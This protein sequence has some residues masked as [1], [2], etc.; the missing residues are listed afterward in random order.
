MKASRSPLIGRVIR[1]DAHCASFGFASE[2]I[3]GA[4]LQAFEFRQ[5]VDSN[6]EKR[7]V[8]EVGRSTNGR[9]CFRPNFAITTTVRN[10]SVPAPEYK[11]C[12]GAGNSNRPIAV[13]RIYPHFRAGFTN[14]GTNA[15]VRALLRIAI[16]VFATIG[17]LFVGLNILGP[18]IVLDQL[19]D[20]SSRVLRESQ[21]PSGEFVASIESSVCKD[22]ARSG[23]TVY[24]R[25]SGE[26]D[27]RGIPFADNSSTDFEL[28]W[29][30]DS[31]LE[32]IGPSQLVTD[33]ETIGS[34]EDVWILTGEF[35]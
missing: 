34:I 10:G 28:T 4:R 15:F 2:Y 5:G 13:I 31:K 25:R 8:G 3:K 35:R 29:V 21:S 14:S 20:C 12:R 7:Q 22:S 6:R 27:R 11:A 32:V 23:T 18:E 19:T 24:L 26:M 33:G 1:S 16:G 30:S 9:V 17:V